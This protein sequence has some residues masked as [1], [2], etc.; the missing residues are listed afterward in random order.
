MS[1]NKYA[2]SEN[3]PESE[4]TPLETEAT[5]LTTP[6]ETEATP[7]S[8]EDKQAVAAQVN[9]SVLLSP[10]ML[11]LFL[12]AYFQLTRTSFTLPGHL[13]NQSLR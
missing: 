12:S 13:A 8:P 6:L 3:D 10:H 9:M 4:A 5:P 1:W 11:W 2:V 7:L